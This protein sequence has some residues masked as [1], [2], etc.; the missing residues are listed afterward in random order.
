[1]NWL[2]LLNINASNSCWL[3]ADSLRKIQ[4]VRLSPEERKHRTD[5]TFLGCLW[6]PKADHYADME[7]DSVNWGHTSGTSF[8]YSV[9]F[10][11]WFAHRMRGK[12]AASEPFFSFG[13]L[14]VQWENWDHFI[15]SCW[16]LRTIC[17]RP[18]LP[19][20]ISTSC[21]VAN[22]MLLICCALHSIIAFSPRSQEQTAALT[23][24]S[25]HL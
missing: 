14:T 22:T 11:G 15:K 24:V 2:S 20:I 13:D 7:D 3:S 18:P 21:Q 9:I 5:N 25:Q 8:P 6:S 1:M 4:W 19:I 17:S 10:F 12:T 16:C 23:V